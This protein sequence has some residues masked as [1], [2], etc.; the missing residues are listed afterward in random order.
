MLTRY[1]SLPMRSTFLHVDVQNTCP[2]SLSLGQPSLVAD[3]QLTQLP[4]SLPNVSQSGTALDGVIN[5]FLSPSLIPLTLTPF[6]HLSLS[7]SLL[8]FCSSC[9]TQ[10]TSSRVC[11]KLAQVASPPSGSSQTV[12]VDLRSPSPQVPLQSLKG[13]PPHSVFHFNR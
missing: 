9:S 8:L 3:N 13:Q 6:L 12:P 7:P 5:E 2:F 4:G 11:G 1:F 10:G